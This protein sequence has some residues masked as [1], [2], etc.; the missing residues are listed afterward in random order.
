LISELREIA[1]C[2]QSKRQSRWR[3]E[4]QNQLIS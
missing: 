1:R 3:E 4:N 2:G